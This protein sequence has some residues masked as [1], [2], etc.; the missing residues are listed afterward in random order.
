MRTRRTDPD[1]PSGEWRALLARPGYPGFAVTVAASQVTSLMFAVSGVLLVLDRT[2]SAA[3]AGATASAAV[4]PAALSGPL[5]GAW[6]DVTA[7]RRPLIVA[8]RVLSAAALVALVALAGHG[9]GWSLPAIAV[10]YGVTT[11][12]SIG[13]FLG[14]QAALAG[15]ELLDRA[16]A[17]AATTA[18]VAVVIG[19]ALAGALAGVIAPADVVELQAALTV[20]TAG[21]IALNPVFDLRTGETAPST[22]HALVA[23][24]QALRER[25]LLRGAIGANSLAAFSWGLMTVGFP[26]YASH[27][28]GAGHNAAGYLWAAVALGSIVGTF[29]LTR[30][31]DPR[32]MAL[33][34]AA[35]GTSALLWPL[36]GSLAAGFGLILFTGLLEGPAF[37]GA[38]AL[39]QRLA[40]DR[41]RTAVLN[42]G[43][44]ITT[45]SLALGQAIGGLTVEKTGAATLAIVV[46]ACADLAAAGLLALSARRADRAGLPG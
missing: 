9:P 5:L 33:S 37:S 36:A 34:Y 44:S 20:L 29:A 7:R 17:V 15:P 45:A 26:V 28:L 3:L 8:D 32:R 16:S 18:N 12:I 14:A 31:A 2:G 41:A 43:Q 23:G 46:F 24:L 21:L 42:T 11:P 25:R 38:V 4:L 27:A 39:Q 1:R 13:S 35:F 22:R 10:L 30:G 6:L 19:P 40:P